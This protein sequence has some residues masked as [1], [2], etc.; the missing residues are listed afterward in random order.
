MSIFRMPTLSSVSARFEGLRD[1]LGRGSRQQPKHHKQR[2]L[3]LDP[4]E[5][6]QLLSVTPA[7]FTDTLINQTVS[8]N[9]IALNGYNQYGANGWDTSQWMA[10]DDDGDF[11][12]TWTRYDD[13]LGA[14]GQPVVDPV[15][16][17][18]MRDANIY[19]RY[20]TD[21]VQRISLPDELAVDNV[22]GQYGKFYIKYGGNE[23]Q[24]LTVS[25]THEPTYSSSGSFFGF[26]YQA[27]I[28]GGITLGFDINGS[29]DIGISETTTVFFNELNPVNTTA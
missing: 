22:D 25:A 12:A 14:N 17:Q 8:E 2:R 9:E 23:V 11:V 18:V 6:R 3:L 28:V 5:E 24:K 21:D 13:V 7:D 16:G 1:R 19:A 15:T 29:G 20:F 26:G 10:M 4:L 27:N